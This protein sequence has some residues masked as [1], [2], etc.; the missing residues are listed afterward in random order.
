MLTYENKNAA[1]VTVAKGKNPRQL[2]DHQNKAM[3]KLNE[4]NRKKD[5]SAIIVLP[6]GAGKTLTAVYWL[7]KNAVNKHTKVLWIA[8]M[9]AVR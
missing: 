3:I 6:T 8:H 5:F 7:L 9:C 4:I 2:Y 1:I